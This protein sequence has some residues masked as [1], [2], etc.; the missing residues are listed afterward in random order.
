MAPTLRVDDEVYDRLKEEA[1]PFVDSPN[2]VLRR[3][4]GLDIPAATPREPRER[5]FR[6]RAKSGEI[7]DRRAYDRPILEALARRG[8]TGPV[9]EVLD[10]VGEALADQLTDRDHEV[11]A[12]G[13]VRW[14]NR[15]M[16]RRLRLVEAGLL[17][18]GS[19]RGIWEL[20]ND[21]WEA[22]SAGS[23]QSA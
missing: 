10:E 3:L 5:D 19:P 9:S 6:G 4:L 8:G 11:I 12:T 20:T 2:S 1:E 7:L 15:A 13:A 14:R 17:R 23:Q 16:W 18:K 21:G 22:L